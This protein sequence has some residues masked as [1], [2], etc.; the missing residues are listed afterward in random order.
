MN[1]W[2]AVFKACQADHPTLIVC[3][4]AL[5][6]VSERFF[7]ISRKYWGDQY[8]VSLPKRE[9]VKEALQKWGYAFDL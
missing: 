5:P 6:S 7:F 1:P 8:Q 9:Q 2:I 4:C 3:P